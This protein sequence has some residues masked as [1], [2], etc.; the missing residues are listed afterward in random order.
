MASQPTTL[1]QPGGTGPAAGAIDFET[2]KEVGFY[3]LVWRRFKQRKIALVSAIM[4]LAITAACFIVPQ[5][6]PA[7]CADLSQLNNGAPLGPFSRGISN[8]QACGSVPAGSYFHLLGTDD[9]GRD[10]LRRVLQGGQI[11]LIVGFLTMTVTMAIATVLGA[12]GGFF[13]GI[14]DTL[15]SAL[16][17]GVLAIPSILILIILTRALNGNNDATL[18]FLGTSSTAVLIIVL[19]ISLILWPTTAR[20][21]RSVI[22]STREK[23]FVEAARAVGT[24]RMRIIVRHLVPNALGPIVVSASLTISAAILTE[25]AISFLGYGIQEPTPTWGKLLD[26]GRSAL[27][28]YPDTG[29]WYAF[30]PGM[31]ILITVLCCN[32]IGDA[33]RD[34]F[35]PRSLER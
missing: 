16:T 20:I 1:V 3:G 11:S 33:L 24:S 23:E 25:S 7:E 26:E 34:A 19:A 14:V 29:I 21:I 31:L 2:T 27:V 28:N 8:G 15:I 35:D 4:L 30:W 12:L 18:L 10:L 22:L 17:N 6:L 9:A 13:G 5:F 32:Y